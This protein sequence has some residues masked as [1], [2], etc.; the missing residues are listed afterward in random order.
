VA[1]LK[2]SKLKI[3]LFAF[4]VR[5]KKR[6]FFLSYVRH[7][8]KRVTSSTSFPK[9]KEVIY[10]NNNKLLQYCKSAHIYTHDNFFKK[11]SYRIRTN[12]KIGG[13]GR[14]HML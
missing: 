2:L 10:S 1:L 13:L 12:E 6:V 4:G 5:N 7:G 3:P 9:N 8:F 14:W 11:H